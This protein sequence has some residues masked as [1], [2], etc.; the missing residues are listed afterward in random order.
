MKKETTGAI[1]LL[2]TLFVCIWFHKVA[3]SAMFIFGMF[4]GSLMAS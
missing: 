4:I 3:L 2:G 1:I